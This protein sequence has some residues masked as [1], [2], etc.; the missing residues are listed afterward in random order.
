MNVSEIFIRRPIA[1]SLLMAA[2]ALFGVVSYRGLPVADLPTVDYPTV[3][4]SA[5]LPGGEPGMM[6]SGV[7]SPLE[8]QFTTIAGVDEMTSS[9]TAGNTN[10]T[11]TFDLDRQ[12]DSAVVDLQTAI[13]AALPLLPS[14]LTAPPSFRKVNPADQPILFMTL[15]S[16]S[17]DLAAIDD[18]AENL[19]APRI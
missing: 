15:T 11:M 5:A 1:T 8:R 3:F 13:S 17:M 18:Y 7:A 19:L 16:N 6:A 14:T 2:I 9:S 10:I 4:V 12:I